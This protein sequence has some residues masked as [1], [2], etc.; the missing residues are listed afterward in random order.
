M[1]IWVITPCWPAT[2]RAFLQMQSL[3]QE[4]LSSCSPSC[5]GCL[6]IFMWC[7]PGPS[8]FCWEKQLWGRD[9]C[10]FALLFWY[11]VF[12]NQELSSDAYHFCRWSCRLI[13]RQIYMWPSAH[14]GEW[15][16]GVKATVRSSHLIQI[17]HWSFS[18]KAA[19]VTH[20]PSVWDFS[21][22]K[23]Q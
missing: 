12:F 7:E 17:R 20:S 4:A 9:C 5:A 11:A 18:G 23:A 22:R 15:G 21:S 19:L 1:G 6:E 14:P 10:F 13:E 2:A 3:L 8:A 16:V